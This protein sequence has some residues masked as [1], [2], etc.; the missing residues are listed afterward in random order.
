MAIVLFPDGLNIPNAKAARIAEAF[1]GELNGGTDATAD[2][3]EDWV[4][5]QLTGYTLGSEEAKAVADIT[6]PAELNL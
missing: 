2:Q 1:A 3:I 5:N 6:P 4:K